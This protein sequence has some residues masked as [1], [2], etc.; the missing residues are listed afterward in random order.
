MCQPK[1]ACVSCFHECIQ[2]KLGRIGLIV[3]WRSGFSGKVLR[4]T[5]G[6]A[7]FFFSLGTMTLNLVI[8]DKPSYEAV[9]E[10]LARLIKCPE[11]N[12]GGLTGSV[13]YDDRP[14]QDAC[15]LCGPPQDDCD[16][17][18]PVIRLYWLDDPM[19]KGYTIPQWV[20]PWAKS[21]MRSQ[22]TRP[23]QKSTALSKDL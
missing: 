23:R 18:G 14:P 16:R 13:W 5:T 15:E 10:I 22:K 19:V 6:A 17:C 1:R 11:C 2:R 4:L 7:L 12:S 8:T 20:S 3:S 21:V 9:S